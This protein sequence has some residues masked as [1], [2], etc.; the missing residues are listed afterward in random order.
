MKYYDE[1]WP[2]WA[3]VL[4]FAAGVAIAVYAIRRNRRK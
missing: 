2:W 4:V 3:Q 1:L